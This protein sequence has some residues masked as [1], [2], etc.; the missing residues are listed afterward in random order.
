MHCLDHVKFTT[1][2][3]VL[4]FLIFVDLKQILKEKKRVEQ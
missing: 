4:I 3:I 1:K 2:H